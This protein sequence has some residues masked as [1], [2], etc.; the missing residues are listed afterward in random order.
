MDSSFSFNSRMR[1]CGTELKLPYSH[2]VTRKIKIL[3][4]VSFWKLG[5]VCYQRITEKADWYK[6]KTN[7][8]GR[9]SGSALWNPYVTDLATSQ[10]V[11]WKLRKGTLGERNEEGTYNKKSQGN[12]GG[13]LEERLCS[14]SSNLRHLWTS[15][16]LLLSSPL[17]LQG[18]SYS[19]NTSLK[20]TNSPRW[21]FHTHSSLFKPLLSSSSL[22]AD[23]FA[24]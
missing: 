17:V 5:I 2:P 21:L 19:E 18:I 15:R 3:I 23:D 22:W 11:L 12:I 6:S 14:V 4:F 13:V 20:R 10:F 1:I 16:H 24:S 7:M 8:S 9:G